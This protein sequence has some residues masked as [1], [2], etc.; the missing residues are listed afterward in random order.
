M[1]KKKA[2][3][4]VSSE[5]MPTAHE[6]ARVVVE[7]HSSERTVRNVLVRGVHLRSPIVEDAIRA[8]WSVIRKQSDT[9]RDLDGA[10]DARRARA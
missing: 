9:E 10:I 2:A 7:T 4:P 8:A 5:R 3:V 6:I 1:K